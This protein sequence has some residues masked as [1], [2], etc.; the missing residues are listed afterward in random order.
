MRNAAGTKHL[1]SA[2]AAVLVTCIAAVATG[3]E[4]TSNSAQALALGSYG[5]ST[6]G[7]PDPWAFGVGVLA[8]YTLPQRV[9]VGLEADYFF[10]GEPEGDDTE[11][12]AFL[13]KVNYFE[14]TLQVGYDHGASP[15]ITLR[16]ALGVGA[17]M[18][19]HKTCLSEADDSGQL[20][21]LGCDR[22]TATDVVMSPSLSVLFRDQISL[23]IRVRYDVVYSKYKLANM[24]GSGDFLT[25]IVATLGV[26]I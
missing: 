19:R 20:Q 21:R 26:G 6:E 7:G 9:F 1:A 13:S 14:P 8:G 17:A 16:P 15:E 18:L 23:M 11:S 12:F 3:R 10:G 22:E 2:A 4:P 5:S 24:E 25:G